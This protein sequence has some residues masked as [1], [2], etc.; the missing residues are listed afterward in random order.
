MKPYNTSVQ[1]L[2]LAVALLAIALDALTAALPEPDPHWRIECP[3][4]AGRCGDTSAV[5]FGYLR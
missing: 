5:T 3:N 4:Y 2:I 1:W